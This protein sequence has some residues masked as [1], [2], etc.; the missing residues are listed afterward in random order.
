MLDQ[1]MKNSIVF[2]DFQ[3]HQPLSSIFPLFLWNGKALNHFHSKSKDIKIQ[4][5][6]DQAFH[7]VFPALYPS[8]CL[9]ELSRIYDLL[10]NEDSIQWELLFSTYARHFNQKTQIAM[11]TFLAL[12]ED[13]K[14]WAED[15]D[16]GVSDFAIFRSLPSSKW[17]ETLV[18]TFCQHSPSK[19][20]GLQILEI[21]GELMLLETSSELLL[22]NS[23]TLDRWLE[24]L[25]QVRFPK[26]Q[27][28]DTET[29]EHISNLPWPKK[30]KP[31]WV[32]LGDRGCMEAKIQFATPQELKE[33]LIN[34]QRVL[35]SW[36]ER[37]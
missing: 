10:K 24:H 20:M 23:A 12:P 8:L 30:L 14:K 9:A 34:F 1:G 31:R 5:V 6:S 19:Q 27:N 16:L 35:D 32:R 26:T 33:Q 28:Q 4:D 25:K 29:K 15:K 13:L 11:E 37:P 36:E 17:P 7:E 18:S 21:T 3:P 22:E 2:L